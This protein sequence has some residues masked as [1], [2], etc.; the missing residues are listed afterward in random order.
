MKTE[1]QY[2][3]SLAKPTRGPKEPSKMKSG[4]R[5]RRRGK[6]HQKRVAEFM[7][8]QNRWPYFGEDIRGAEFSVEAKTL[9][10]AYP[11]T[12]ETMLQEAE[13]HANKARPGAVAVLNIHKSGSGK[14]LDGDLM[15]MRMKDFR[16]MV[17]TMKGI[18][19]EQ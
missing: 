18:S 6:D 12:V 8:W 3:K 13:V 5:A 7:G 14:R 11:Q 16:W 19:N 1:Q 15:I 4:A 2:S 17:E 10:S 9:D